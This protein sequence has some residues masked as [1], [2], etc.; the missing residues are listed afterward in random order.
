MD[1][2]TRT[3]TSNNPTQPYP[4]KEYFYPNEGPAYTTYTST[5]SAVHIYIY[6][7]VAIIS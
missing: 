7:L 5:S 1:S 6:I 4:L 3:E 2:I